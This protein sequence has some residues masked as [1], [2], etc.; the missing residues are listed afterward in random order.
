MT[1]TPNQKLDIKLQETRDVHGKKRYFNFGV[2]V[3]LTYDQHSEQKFSLEP[4]E[5]RAAKKV[6]YFS[7]NFGSWV[8]LAYDQHSEQKYSR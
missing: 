1:N 6:N 3:Q 2:W 4:P 5:N 7:F 8:Q